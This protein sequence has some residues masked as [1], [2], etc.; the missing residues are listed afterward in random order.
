MQKSNY[1]KSA[2]KHTF[3]FVI[4]VGI[5]CLWTFVVYPKIALGVNAPARVTATAGDAEV[6]LEWTDPNLGELSPE[7]IIGYRIYYFAGKFGEQTVDTGDAELSYTVT[8]LENGT[9]YTFEVATL[10]DGSQSER[11]GRV[12]ATPV[13]IGQE[14][15][16]IRGEPT[17][18]VTNTGVTISW[19]TTIS[20]TSVVEYGPTSDFKGEASAGAAKTT[21]HSIEITGLTSCAGYWFKVI[22]YDDNSNLAESQ[23]GEFKTTGCKGESSILTYQASRATNL[24]GTTVTVTNSGRFIEVVAPANIKN[25]LDAVAIE[26]MKLEK[27][28]VR[29]EIS[30]PPTKQW[31]GNAYSLKAFEDERTELTDSFDA[32]VEV[33]ISY[34]AEDIAGIDPS[35]LTIYHYEDGSGW[36]ALSNCSVNQSDRTVTCETTSFSIF[37]LFGSE[38]SSGGE[39][40][41]SGSYPKQTVKS[42][43]VNTVDIKNTET[44]ITPVA[45]D[46]VLTQTEANLENNFQK[47]LK[48]GQKDPDVKK[49]QQLLNKLGFS[50]ALYGPGSLG[51]ETEYFGPLTFAAL[52]KLQEVYKEQ[53]LIPYGLVKGTGFF[54]ERTRM[55]VNSIK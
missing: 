33:T 29:N 13:E 31:I 9:E 32:P 28:L 34:T 51:N 54:G 41:S 40:T 21:D 3:V 45:A 19:T 47:N 26:A 15:I 44:E 22:S 43:V 2:H 1:L 46:P 52:V 37:G 50:V 42:P 8:G 10:I 48:F 39:V 30:V 14:P 38:E 25:G 12:T 4:I 17:A 53:I 11:S 49:L 20:G 5:I 55:F 24:S 35:T 16:T 6:L 36:R 23:D 18:S 7:V 27:E